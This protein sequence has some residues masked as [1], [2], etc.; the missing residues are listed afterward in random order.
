MPNHDLKAEEY[1]ARAR[2]AT[3]AADSATLTRVRERH[4]QAARTWADLAEAEDARVVTRRAAGRPA[5]VD[6]ER[7]EA[8]DVETAT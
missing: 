7:P 4:E 5:P 1:R 2:A 3:A 8:L 6:V